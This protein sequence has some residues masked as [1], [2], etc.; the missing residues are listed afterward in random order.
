MIVQKF[1]NSVVIWS[2][3]AL[4]GDFPGGVSFDSDTAVDDQNAARK[5]GG[6]PGLQKMQFEV[7]KLGFVHEN[8]LVS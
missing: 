1:S 5:L 2:D 8:R 3:H 4:H 7:G 6:E